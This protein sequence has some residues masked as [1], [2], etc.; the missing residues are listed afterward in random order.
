MV[1]CW[2]YISRVPSLPLQPTRYLKVADFCILFF[3]ILM[4]PSD[5][6]KMP[7][8]FVEG[9]E[10]YSLFFLRSCPSCLSPRT[11]SLLIPGACLL[12]TRMRES[13]LP[14]SPFYRHSLRF[15]RLMCCLSEQ[16]ALYCGETWTWEEKACV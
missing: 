15:A 13:C 16:G 1:T 6:R 3:L 12:H 8:Y 9:K 2:Y 5:S 7:I 4:K 14:F 10:V 11:L